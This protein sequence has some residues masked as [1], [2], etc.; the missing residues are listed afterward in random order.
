MSDNFGVSSDPDVF[1]VDKILDMKFENG[2]TYY[3]IKW[4]HYDDTYNTWEPASNL[5]CP[6]KLAEFQAT[7][8][9][10][11]RLKEYEDMLNSESKN[12]NSK[13]NKHE[14]E[15]DN[16]TM[17][18]DINSFD[19]D[20][21]YESAPKKALKSPSKTTHKSPSKTTQKSPSKTTHKSPSKTTQKSP[22]KTT[23]KSPSK[24]ASKEK[25]MTL[26]HFLHPSNQNS[27][28]STDIDFASSESSTEDIQPNQTPTSKQQNLNSF[29]DPMFSIKPTP[30]TSTP[31][32]LQPPTKFEYE[33]PKRGTKKTLQPQKEEQIKQTID[34]S[35]VS[36]VVFALNKKSDLLESRLRPVNY[37]RL[38]GIPD[39]MD[40]PASF[41]GQ[42]IIDFHDTKIE[43]NH[44]F[45]LAQLS[46]GER[47]W[48]S[49]DAA[50]IINKQLLLTFL[51][52][53]YGIN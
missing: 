36:A 27:E 32:K 19:S 28:S 35:K 13:K 42:P 12:S 7:D 3:W 49:L 5:E 30:K 53:K 50:K 16:E 41:K 22:S 10:I 43:N 21:G 51:L 11:Q 34:Y 29:N 26:E 15:S 38:Y 33:Q 1:E 40:L 37:K 24:T 39:K 44:R 9:Y 48:I 14:Y 47:E 6:D 45:V 17:T 20:Y 46:S 2:E 31:Q 8:M 18:P 25:H 52:K 4:M 23:Q